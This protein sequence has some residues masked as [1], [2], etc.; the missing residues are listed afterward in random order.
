[1][2]PSNGG[3]WLP[4]GKSVFTRAS[5][6]ET[7]IKMSYKILAFTVLSQYEPWEGLKG[8]R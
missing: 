7:L 3:P 5:A 2:V 1:M 4:R 6:S 8:G